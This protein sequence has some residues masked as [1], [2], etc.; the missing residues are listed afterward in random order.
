MASVLHTLGRH[1]NRNCL[2]LIVTVSGEIHTVVQGCEY[3]QP[4][5][6][7]GEGVLG[8]LGVVARRIIWRGVCVCSIHK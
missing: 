2:N 8:L 4:D 6:E 1:L 7:G 3:L 5:A